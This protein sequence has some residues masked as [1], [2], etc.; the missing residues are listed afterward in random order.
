MVFG[1]KATSSMR[2]T[3]LFS[4][5]IF[6]FFLVHISNA[7]ELQIQHHNIL[8]KLDPL[9]HSIAARDTIKLIGL[10]KNEQVVKLNLHPSLEVEEILLGNT[11][12]DFWEEVIRSSGKSMEPTKLHL[13]RKIEIHLPNRLYDSEEM[14]LRVSYRGKINDSPRQAP[15]LRYVRP[16]VTNG[17]IGDEGVYLTSETVWYPDVTG[18]LASFHL[19]V[20]LPKTWRAVTH[21]QEVSFVTQE[22][23]S[24]AEWN[25]VAKTEALTLVANR[26]IKQ[27]RIWNGIEVSTYLF[28]EDNHLADRYLEATIHY[29]SLYVEVLGPYPFPK[30]SVVENFFPSGLGLPSF[31]LLGSRIIKRGYTQPYSLGHEI[32]HSWFGNSVLNHFDTGNWV[33]GLTTYL[34]NYYYVERFESYKQA[35]VQRRRMI[36]E[37]SLY[38]QPDADYPVIKFHHKENRL[39]NAIGYKKAAMIFHMLR[40]QVGDKVF[41]H[42]LKKLVDEYTGAYVKWSDLKSLFEQTAHT[43]LEWFF[44]Q[45]IKRPGA[46]EIQIAEVHVQ[47]DVKEGFW[48]RMN[49]I[50]IGTPYHLRIPASIQLSNDGEY[51]LVLDIHGNDQLMS[52]WV[53]EKPVRLMLDPGF[54]VFR[55][56]KRTQIPPMLNLWVTD[57]QR[58][59]AVPHLKVDQN[60]FKPA[61]DRIYSQDNYLNELEL[62]S[63]SPTGQSILVFGGPAINSSATTILEWCGSLVSLRKEGFTI[64]EESFKGND[65]ALLVTC[66][67]PR[68]PE[69]VG[70]LFFGFSGD[71]VQSVARLLFFYGWDSYLVFKH[72]KVIF[73][74]SFELVTH[75]LEVRL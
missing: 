61:L 2:L 22:N 66:V 1:K 7:G 71:A 10:S 17:Y 60:A 14:E 6:W 31:T 8:V 39:D 24:I 30:F 42:S 55:R 38:G 13:T 47:P 16:N 11:P 21:G 43:N 46:P 41:F 18:S 12:L 4:L 15:G 73:R 36:I 49:I 40:Q 68:D 27:A 32:V 64:R 19:I 70:V 69:H 75:D 33:E 23:S 26:F 51:R 63:S 44:T 5:L 37:Y 72:G 65:V 52:L 53:P 34:A 67:N 9:S 20:I 45:W 74:G 57:G 35:L 58:V 62:G 48:I 25:V 59:L 3:C 50:Q 56:L 29:L 28:H 54:E